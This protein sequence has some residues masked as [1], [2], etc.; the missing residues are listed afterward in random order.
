MWCQWHWKFA[1]SV[2]VCHLK[3]GCWALYLHFSGNYSILD[4]RTLWA[5]YRCIVLEVAFWP[6]TNALVLTLDQEAC[7]MLFWFLSLPDQF[8]YY[9]LPDRTYLGIPSITWI[10]PYSWH[11][12][13]RDILGRDPLYY[14]YSYELSLFHWR[15]LMVGDRF[16]TLE[17]YIICK[18]SI[19]DT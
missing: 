2:L 10:P 13:S 7:A 9:S 1:V 5:E 15:L 3:D 11:D 12:I 19:Y 16:G 18:P 8:C 17:H 4:L 6:C 14:M